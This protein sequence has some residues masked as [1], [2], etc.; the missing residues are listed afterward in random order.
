MVVP[1]FIHLSVEVHFGCCQVEV[2]MSKSIKFVY[3]FLFKCR[4]LI[5]SGKYLGVESLDDLVSVWLGN[6]LPNFSKV[7]IILHSHW[8]CLQHP[9]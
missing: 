1:L 2:I 3:K 5:H 7:T 4:F 6:R 9:I 8:K